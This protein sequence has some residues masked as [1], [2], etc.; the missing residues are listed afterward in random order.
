MMIVKVA[1]AAA[2]TKPIKLM[3]RSAWPNIHFI[4]IVNQ[5]TCKSMPCN[6][7]ISHPASDTEKNCIHVTDSRYGSLK[8]NRWLAVG[9][10]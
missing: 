10:L 8:C 9:S 5:N 4:A 2:I 6:T 1:M 3:E 7:S